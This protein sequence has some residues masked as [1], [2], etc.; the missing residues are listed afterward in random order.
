MLLI[1]LLPEDRR[2]VERT[3]LPRLLSV[4]GGVLL[5]GVELAVI[6]LFLGVKVPEAERRRTDAGNRLL[7]MRQLIVERDNL[8]AELAES[9]QRKSVIM[10][11]CRKR[12]RWTEKLDAICDRTVLPDL[13][14][15]KSLKIESKAGTLGMTEKHLVIEGWARGDEPRES[16]EAINKFIK[17]LESNE[18]FYSDFEGRLSKE[19]EW[20]G[21]RLPGSRDK[22]KDAPKDAMWFT[23]R[24]KLKPR[25]AALATAGGP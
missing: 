3:P 24:A 2:P 9:E 17:R 19:L 20:K 1:D 18:R 16:I 12:V 8:K 14:W 15:L 4:I 10:Q 22:H 11:I 21:V 7:E 13:V 23:T 25:G 5:A 6:A